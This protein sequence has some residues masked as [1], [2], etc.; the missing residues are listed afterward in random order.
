MNLPVVALLFGGPSEEYEISLRSAAHILEEIDPG[1][2]S[3]LPVG[4]TRFGGW[5][6]CAPDPDMIRRDEWFCHCDRNVPVMPCRSGLLFPDAPERPLRPAAVFPALHGAWGEDGR[7]QGLLD[8]L[9]IP[10]VGCGQETSALCMNKAQTKAVLRCAGLPVTDWAEISPADMDDPDA[11]T[12]R[13]TAALP[14]PLFVKPCRGGSSIG[15][16]PVKT[17]AALVPALREALL[18][19]SRALVEPLVDALECEVAVLCCG[20]EITVSRPGAILTD[21]AFYH[22][23]AKYSDPLTRTVVPAPLPEAA[24]AEMRRLAEKAFGVLGCRHLARVDFF[25]RKCDGNIFINEINALP[26]M[27]ER[28]LWPTLMEDCGIPFRDCL[29]RLIGAAV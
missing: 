20:E 14:L 27:T 17:E 24:Q 19:D 3:V 7:L 22:Y 9:S 18:H 28:S 8:C 10:Y 11:L 15:A 29:T 6:R 25:F 4:V 21:A 26:G 1:R 2:F 12:R 23:R 16:A 5:F 13:I